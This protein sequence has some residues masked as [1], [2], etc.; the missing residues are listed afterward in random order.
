[1]IAR[2]ARFD[3]GSLSHANCSKRVPACQ[4]VDWCD[5]LNSVSECAAAGDFVLCCNNNVDAGT[6]SEFG[7]D[8]ESGSVTGLGGAG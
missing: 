8:V 3:M 1:M 2:M 4:C 7:W 5:Q 6:V